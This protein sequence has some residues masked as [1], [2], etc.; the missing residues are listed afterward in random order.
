[1]DTDIVFK[2]VIDADYSRI[3]SKIKL[4]NVFLSIDGQRSVKTVASED[5]YEIDEL[6]PMVEQ[7]IDLGLV[8]IAHENSKSVDPGFFDFLS[9]VLA[10][11]LGPMGEIILEDTLGNLGFKKGIFPKD[12]LQELIDRLSLEIGDTRKADIFKKTMAAEI[13]RMKK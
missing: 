1:M 11:E 10:K 6:I 3:V 2:R 7:L 13:Q 4:V 8:M 12:S 9:D 5:N